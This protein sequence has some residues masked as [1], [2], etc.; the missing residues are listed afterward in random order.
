MM[1]YLSFQSDI[2]F[3]ATAAVSG[4]SDSSKEMSSKS[5]PQTPTAY[6]KPELPLPSVEGNVISNCSNSYH[7]SVR[8]ILR[9]DGKKCEFL[10]KSV[11]D[12]RFSVFHTYKPLG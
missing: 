1:G 7:I 8:L 9:K 12:K 5:S 11:E 10:P 3:K 6:E 2:Y 4:S